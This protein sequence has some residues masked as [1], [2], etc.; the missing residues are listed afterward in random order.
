MLLEL[1]AARS[2]N[3]VR[4]QPGMSTVAV[5]PDPC[6]SLARLSV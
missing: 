3:S 1:I 6:S 2:W 5:T 4:T